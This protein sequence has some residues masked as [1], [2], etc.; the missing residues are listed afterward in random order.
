LTCNWEGLDDD[1][2]LHP[3]GLFR[4]CPVCESL[5]IVWLID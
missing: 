4:C 1:L 5:D 3:G 2:M